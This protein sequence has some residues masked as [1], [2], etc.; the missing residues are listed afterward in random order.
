MSLRDQIIAVNDLPSELMDVPEWGV[1]IKVIGLTGAGRADYIASGMDENGERRAVWM[2][3]STPRLIV[4]GVC[5]PDTDER[6][7]TLADLDD[8]NGKNAAVLDKV[9]RAVARLSGL[10]VDDEAKAEEA[11]VEA[12]FR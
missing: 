2:K 5:D 1:T 9:A 3:L 12:E 6:I 10:G 7:F 4:E 11:V 8:I